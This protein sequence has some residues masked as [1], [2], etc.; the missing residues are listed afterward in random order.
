MN[1]LV[2]GR[3]LQEHGVLCG[4]TL[5]FSDKI[6]EICAAPQ[7]GDT[8]IDA[9]RRYISPGLID[10]HIHGYRGDNASDGDAQGLLRMGEALLENGVTAF[11]P[12]TMT[13]PLP[14]LRR[15]FAAIRQAQGQTGFAGAQALFCHAE[16][17][18]INPLKK[19]AQAESAILPPDAA[20]LAPDRDVIRLVTLAPEMEG[21]LSCIR[22]LRAAGMRVSIGHTCAGYETARE[23]LRAGC[24]HFTHLFNAMP[25]LLHRD[26]GAVGAALSGSAWCELIADTF[27][28]HPGLFPLLRRAAGER[29]V[30]VSDCTRAGGLTDGRYTLGGQEITV[31]GI[32]CR[33]RDG[34]IAGSVLRLNDA[35]RNYHVHSG[36]PLHE[37]VACATI[38]AARSVGIEG[39]KGALLPGLDADIVL[40]DEDARVLGVYTRGVRRL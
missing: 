26:P 18:F 6:C 11:L 5:R 19:G 16:G 34:T 23:A 2:N 1:A 27:H 14:A 37:A 25:P 38:H 32:E 8:V 15:A 24:D 4:Q 33:L 21:A 20:L 10:I 30:L 9:G 36:A 35:V 13:L 28:V 7:A 12:T 29:L 22:A 31:R 39:Q 17:P 40:M 3:I